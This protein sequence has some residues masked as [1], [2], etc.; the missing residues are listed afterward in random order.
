MKE[1][2]NGFVRDLVYLLLEQK[3]ESA[4]NTKEDLEMGQYIGYCH[5][6][7]I[8]YYQA[9]AFGISLEDIGLANYNPDMAVFE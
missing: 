6:L 2:E 5:A 9:L 8:I 7:S 3:D 4:K 1:I